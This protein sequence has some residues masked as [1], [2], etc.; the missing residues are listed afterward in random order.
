[1]AEVLAPEQP[2][3]TVPDEDDM[4]R[5]LLAVLRHEQRIIPWNHLADAFGWGSR[6]LRQAARTANQRLQGAGLRVHVVTSGLALR[7]NEQSVHEVIASVESLR[8]R[9]E[10]RDDG[11]ARI[12]HEVVTGSIAQAQ[13]RKGYGPR[14]G[15]LENQG[16]VHVGQPGEDFIVPPEDIRPAFDI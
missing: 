9:D 2:T 13:I 5:Q 4:A 8:A 14:L 10:S 12:L 7:A 3:D 11:T 1:M 16:K 15:Y 6:D